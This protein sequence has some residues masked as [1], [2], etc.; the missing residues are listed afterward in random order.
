MDNKDLCFLGSSKHDIVAFPDDARRE[1][2]YQL[3]LI[4]SGEESDDFKP[5]SEIGS[6]VK[7]IRIH[8]GN[9]YRIMYV[10]KFNKYIYVLH[11]FVKKQQKT[12]KSDINLAKDR[13]KKIISLRKTL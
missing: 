10:A 13:Y 8:K 4:Q 6:G 11:A 9:E 1:V 3:G 7:E 12:N 2:G 5:L